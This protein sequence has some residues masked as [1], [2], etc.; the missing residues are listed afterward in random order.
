MKVAGVRE[1][2]TED[3]GDEGGYFTVVTPEEKS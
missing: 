3:R 1:E 2:D